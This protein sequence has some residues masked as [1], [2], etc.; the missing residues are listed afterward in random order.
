MKRWKT[1]IVLGLLVFGIGGAFVAAQE[2]TD[3]PLPWRTK[4]L[5][6]LEQHPEVWEEIQELRQQY[7]AAPELGE[8]QGFFGMMRGRVMQMRQRDTRMMG[9]RMGFNQNASTTPQWCGSM[10]GPW[11]SR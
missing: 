2:P 10:M 1:L 8:E 7:E 4:V 9:R 5:E 6:I 11:W 3:Q